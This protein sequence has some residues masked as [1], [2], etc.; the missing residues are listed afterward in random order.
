MREGSVVLV[1]LPQADGQPKPRPA[2]VLRAMPPFQDFLLAG[3]SSQLRQA[4]AGFD[5]L[6]VVGSDDF[7]LS[8]LRVSSVV[9]L[10]FLTVL[11]STQVLGE[12]GTISEGLRQQLLRRLSSY[13][14][15]AN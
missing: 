12:S 9:R 11:P 2:L 15:A 1:I 6:L 10:G 4:V 7:G 8:G 14:L 3:I 13:L 5:E